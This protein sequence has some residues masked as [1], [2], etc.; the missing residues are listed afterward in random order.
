ML[1]SSS[2]PEKQFTKYKDIK[3]KYDR[4]SV[5]KDYDTSS[6]SKD[7]DL[8]SLAQKSSEVRP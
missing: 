5:S 4:S 1:L 6:L 3:P 2:S 8:T 7:Y